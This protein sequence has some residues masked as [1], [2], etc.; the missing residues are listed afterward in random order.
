MP[1]IRKYK[2]WIE[3]IRR[4]FLHYCFVNF[5]TVSYDILF[6]LA[7]AIKEGAFFP[8]A[9]SRVGVKHLHNVYANPKRTVWTTMFIPSEIPVA[10][11]LYPFCSAN[12]RSAFLL[13]SAKLRGS[14]RLNRSG[15]HGYLH[16]SP[17]RNRTYIQKSL[18]QNILQA[19]TTTL[20]DQ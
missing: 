9:F 11:G 4:R 16:L 7:G 3:P 20:L 2:E 10:M 17:V 14:W 15:F 6:F 1:S 13:V 12:R 5:F 8:L 18:S 19:A